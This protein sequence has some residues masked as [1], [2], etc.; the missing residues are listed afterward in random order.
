M[1][2]IRQAGWSVARDER[3][4]TRLREAK[5]GPNRFTGPLVVLDLP[6]I[7]RVVELIVLRCGAITL[8]VD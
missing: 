4:I 7:V 3:G 1:G 2:L 8:W 6:N 5:I